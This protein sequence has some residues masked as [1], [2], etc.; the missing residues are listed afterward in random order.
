MPSDQGN[1]QQ[2]AVVV[3]TNDLSS[4]SSRPNNEG[5][6]KPIAI[7]IINHTVGSI[8]HVQLLT[9]IKRLCPSSTDGGAAVITM[10]L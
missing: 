10:L 6:T 2:R 7:Y 5:A 1:S 3:L 4:D 8:F 9:R